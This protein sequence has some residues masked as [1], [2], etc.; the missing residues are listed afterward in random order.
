MAK[1]YRVFHRQ[2]AP[3]VCGGMFKSSRAAAGDV[4][5]HRGEGLGVVSGIGGR[6]SR[7]RSAAGLRHTRRNYL[8]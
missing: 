8:T 3:R 2:D 1:A 5:A 7:D 4:N 6:A